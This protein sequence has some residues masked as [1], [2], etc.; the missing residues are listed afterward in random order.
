[1]KKLLLLTMLA[2]TFIFSQTITTIADGDY[3][4]PFAWDCTCIPTAGVDAI[5]NHDMTTPNGVLVDGGS[6]L[7]NSGKSITLS[8]GAAGVF[9]TNGAAL[10]NYGTFTIQDVTFSEGTTINSSGSIIADSLFNQGDF[11]NSGIITIYD[12]A[13]D[14][15]ASLTN[16]GTIDIEHNFNNQGLV[17]NQQDISV[18]LDFSNCNTQALDAIFENNGTMCVVNDFAN[19][20]GDTLSGS[21]SYYAG[22]ASGNAGVFAGTHTFYTASGSLSLNTGTIQPTVTISSGTNSCTALSIAEEVQSNLTAYP[23]P[24]T[25]DISIDLGQTYNQS[26]VKVLN[27]LG[28]VVFTQTY[29]SASQINLNID[30]N[31]GMYILEI[32][33][34]EGTT[35][36]IS[37]LKN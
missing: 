9:V 31:P 7:I 19:C 16:T 11:T 4:N 21:G 29:S 22:G 36:R 24:T 13:N 23:N 17:T 18:G 3:Y 12:I 2:P 25:G 5:V 33:T 28:Q 6:L 10:I 35:S 14:E 37:V 8:A 15:V 20:E 30:G 26:D 27:M 34:E 1:M 32:N